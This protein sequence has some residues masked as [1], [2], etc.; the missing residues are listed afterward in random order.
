MGTAFQRI[1]LSA[2]GGGEGRGEVGAA[3]AAHYRAAHLTLPIARAMG[4]FPLPPKTG[5]E[6]LKAANSEPR[7]DPRTRLL[8]E[9][10]IVRT[11]MR[12]AAPNILVMLAQASTPRR[13]LFRWKARDRCP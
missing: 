2:P 12:M 7:R 4:P 11:L 9:A 1:S 8:L 10:P 3:A 6:G 5:G 13:N